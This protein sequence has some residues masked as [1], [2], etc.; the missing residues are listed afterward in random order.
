MVATAQHLK[1]EIKNF[2]KMHEIIHHYFDYTTD[3]P[4]NEKSFDTLLIK[5]GYLP[6]DYPKEFRANKG[7]GMLLINKKALEYAFNTYTDFEKMASFFN[8]NN[9]VLKIRILDEL[10]YSHN[11]SYKQ[12]NLIYNGYYFQQQTQLK[13][14]LFK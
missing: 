3:I 7:A 11:L 12:A 4:N 6:E 9:I 2:T 5:K 14:I 13:E 1:I 8:V 10:I